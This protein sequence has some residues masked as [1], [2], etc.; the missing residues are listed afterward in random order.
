VTVPVAIWFGRA[1]LPGTDTTRLHHHV[2][3]EAVAVDDDDAETRIDNVHDRTLR[4]P[5]SP[6]TKRGQWR[7]RRAAKTDAGLV[8]GTASRWLEN[9]TLTQGVALTPRD[10]RRRVRDVR[11]RDDAESG[12]LGASALVQALNSRARSCR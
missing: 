10:H 9:H 5:E 1:F 11:S 6:C 4:P 2:M 12:V 3:V 8:A 7:S